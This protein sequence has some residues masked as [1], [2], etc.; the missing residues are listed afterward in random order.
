[1]PYFML[2]DQLPVN[3][4]TKTLTAPALAG[5]LRGLAAGFMWS[6]AGASS[7]ASLS[8]GVISLLDLISIVYDKALA[9]ELADL[10]VAAGFWHAPGHECARCDPVPALSWRFHDWADLKYDRGEVVRETR[11]KMKELKNPDIVDA[12]WA[13]DSFAHNLGVAPCRYCG[14]TVKRSDRRSD[15]NNRPTLDHVDPAAARGVEN[16]VVACGSCNRT[17]G[18]RTAAES[19][20]RLRPAPRNAPGTQGA[21][22]VDSPGSPAAGSTPALAQSSTAEPISPGAPAAGINPQDQPGDQIGSES[23]IPNSEGL[24]GRTRG[25]APAHAPGSG[26]GVP[27]VGKGTG[28]PGAGKPAASPSR[29]RRRKRRRGGGSGAPAETGGGVESAGPAPL[30]PG[31]GHGYGSPWHG[32]RG[33]PSPIAEENV[34]PEHGLNDPCWK[35][36]RPRARS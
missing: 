8:D 25:G 12:V 4:K 36:Q 27:G 1:M 13:R 34:C 18:R 23:E 16:L 33:R 7:Q 32:H 21:A 30:V 28:S 11:S 14:K 5:D 31:S 6:L 17:K 2:D 10:L 24:L 9:I 20:M 35:C 15:V 19:G 3:R 29:S 22:A 26:L